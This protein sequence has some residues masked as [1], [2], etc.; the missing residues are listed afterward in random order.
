MK[1]FICF[2]EESSKVG[3]LSFDDIFKRDNKQRFIDLATSGNLKTVNGKLVNS[4]SAD[5]ELI[6][7]LQKVDSKPDNIGSLFSKAY[8]ASF[9]SLGL[10]KASNGFSTTKADKLPN[11]GDVAEG[12]LATAIFAKFA[13]LPLTPDTI[14]D[15]LQNKLKLK[16]EYVVKNTSAPSDTIVLYVNL[17]KGNFS[18]L[19]SKNSA[20][21]AER[22]ELVTSAI[23]YANSRKVKQYDDYFSNNNIES[24]LRVVADGLG[25]QKNTK[26]DLYVELQRKQMIGGKDPVIFKRRLDLNIS[27]K[28]GDIKQFGQVSGSAFENQK[29]LWKTFGLSISSI[30][31]QYTS[32][33]DQGKV[34]DAIALAYNTAYQVFKTDFRPDNEDITPISTLIKSIIHHATLGENIDLV[35]LNKG[36]FK[37]YTFKILESTL[38]AIA[39]NNDFDVIQTKDSSKGLPKLTILLNKTPF[40]SIRCKGENRPSGLYIRNYIEKEKSFEEIFKSK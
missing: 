17:S 1:S 6:Q 36:K 2:I 28:V 11:K 21:I 4:I 32:L 25:G 24:T 26:S 9:S 30:E 22:K 14:E 12:I 5:S 18:A 7:T 27:L 23:E 10:A 35:S 20:L 16:M 29:E 39:Q 3:Q 31:S 8:G 13:K 15:I 40:L 37:R 38:K 33:I 19:T 34:A